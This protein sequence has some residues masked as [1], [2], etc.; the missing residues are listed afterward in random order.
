MS[1]SLWPAPRPCAGTHSLRTGHPAL[2]RLLSSALLLAPT[3][4]PRR[5]PAAPALRTARR[6]LLT[7]AIESSCDDTCV[8]VLEK[9]A[10]TG[11]ARLHFHE[12][13]TSDSR[14]TRGV[15]PLTA[16]LGH[17]RSLA[18]LLRRALRSLPAPPP[19][20]D[21]D[22]PVLWVDGRRRRRPD[23]VC[24]TRG[25][26][27]VSG[28]AAGLNTAKGLAVAWDVPLVGVH[29]MQAHALTPRLVSALA[30]GESSSAAAAAA[31][32]EIS[33]SDS[34]NSD[35]SRGGGEPEPRFPFLS[36]LV[37][38]GHSLLVRSGGLTD[39]AILSQARQIALGDMLDKTGRCVVP[40]AYLAAHMRPGDSFGSLLESFAFGSAAPSY[41]C[42]TPPARRAD[43]TAPYAPA[44]CG[45]V[46]TPP[47][48]QRGTGPAAAALLDFNGLNSQ[49][50]RA[51]AAAPDMP[52]A[53]RR[54][55]ARAAMRL[56]FEHVA[57]RVVLAL[58]QAPHPPVRHVV[59]AGGVASNRFLR[60]VVR[61]FLDAR[62][63]ADV[64]LVCPPLP[65]C[66]DNAAM[67]AWAGMEMF[68]AGW[69]TDLDVL[70]FRRWPLE[71]EPDP[72]AEGGG[73]GGGGKSGVL[74]VPGWR[75]V[76][77]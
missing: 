51:V 12:K 69:R 43:E 62:G 11:R 49:V 38:G 54:L 66:T 21:R 35:H 42:Y 28:L 41:A 72:D 75:R 2:R 52:E 67:I 57:G 25:P 55:L 3:A 24:A 64:E 6:P 23:F 59:M 16:A 32:E 37:S 40:A 19:P 34:S 56:A 30:L 45:W 73:G 44:G 63:F 68:E 36:L 4:P 71:A 9:A 46:L 8:A 60:H 61:R 48:G 74:A 50:E 17:N 39:H 5:P 76:E 77:A 14:A 7:L 13:V 10:A 18:P 15:H 22:A 58:Q 47:M 1:G 27:N 26:G 20:G 65:L 31:E 29:H 33:T 70:V 53:E